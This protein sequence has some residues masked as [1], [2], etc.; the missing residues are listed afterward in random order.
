MYTGILNENELISNNTSL[1]FHIE[2]AR[3]HKT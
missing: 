3:G 2:T 1:E